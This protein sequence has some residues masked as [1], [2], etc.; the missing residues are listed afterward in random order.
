MLKYI[1]SN[2]H[3]TLPRKRNRGWNLALMLAGALALGNPVYVQA[4][5]TAGQMT[6]ATPA[7]IG[8]EQGAPPVATS[9]TSAD[10]LANEL[11]ALQLRDAASAFALLT[12][13]RQ[14]A[15]DN[16]ARLYVKMV[17][18]TQHAL[19]NHQ[20]FRVLDTNV[21]GNSA[22]HKI[23]LRDHHGQETLAIIHLLQQAD[24]SWRIDKAAL[25]PHGD[26]KGA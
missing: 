24:G 16:N 18:L 10:V 1:M 21:D 11:R 25:I 15:L 9:L 5:E 23:Q 14:A 2:D 3:S 13:A 26:D 22:I 17:R 12:P 4:G 7:S 6:M 19:Y 20:S 8:P